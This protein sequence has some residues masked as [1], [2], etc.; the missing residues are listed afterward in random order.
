M[1]CFIRAPPPNTRIDS[2]SFRGSR[3]A[4]FAASEGDWRLVLS[5]A[6]SPVPP[7]KDVRALFD[8]VKL[9]DLR[10]RTFAAQKTPQKNEPTYAPP[11]A[12]DVTP[13]APAVNTPP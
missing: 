5:D 8:K 11:Q 3:L 12:A 4:S 9:G 2:G 10:Y 1:L 7:G 6:G 13:D